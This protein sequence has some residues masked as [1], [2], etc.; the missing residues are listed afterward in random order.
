[1]ILLCFLLALMVLAAEGDG[2]SPPTTTAH[3]SSM[4][5]RSLPSLPSFCRR[6]R[7]PSSPVCVASTS[8]TTA[9]DDNEEGWDL[10]GGY[11]E[12]KRAEAGPD[13]DDEVSPGSGHK[14]FAPPRGGSHALRTTH[15]TITHTRSSHPPRSTPYAFHTGLCVLTS[16]PPARPPSPPAA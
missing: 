6:L 16:A 12:A 10:G 5:H 1:M 14:V 11:I 2:I 4:P 3:T 13:C 7:R 15:Y 8:T 9:G